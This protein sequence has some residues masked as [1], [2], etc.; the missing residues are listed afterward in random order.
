MFV[1]TVLV[2][3]PSP[4]SQKRL[5]IVPVEL[6]VKLTVSGLAPLVGFAVK[7][8]A[9]TSAPAPTSALVL[10][11]PLLVRTNALVKPPALTGA[12]LTITCPVWPGF[13]LKGL[14][15]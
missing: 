12:K 6:S 10:L 11:P 14:P 8:A 1:A 3:V 13:K 5:V 2:V 9:G 15:L 4:K 7:L